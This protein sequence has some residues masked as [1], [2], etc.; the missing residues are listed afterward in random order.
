MRIGGVRDGEG[1][2]V[3]RLIFHLLRRRSGQVP[4]PLRI[5]A[6]RPGILLGFGRLTRAVESPGPLP[7][8]LKRLAMYWTARL[9]ECRY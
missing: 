8:R 3:V 7:D 1:S 6:H 4:K 2:P 5:Y 9:V